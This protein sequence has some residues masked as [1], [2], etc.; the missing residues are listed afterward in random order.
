[1]IEQ[2]TYINNLGRFETFRGSPDTALRPFTLVYSENGCGKTTLCALLRSL[3]SGD[4]EPLHARKRVS[5]KNGPHAV[6][7]VEG[8]ERAFNG[9]AWNGAGPKVLVFDDHFTAANVC[10]GLEVGAGHRQKLHELVVGEDG[11]RLQRRVEE[12]TE[13]I[14]GHQA[15]LR[16][17]VREIPPHVLGDNSLDD[18]CALPE[19]EN[20]DAQLVEATKCASVLRNQ[21][22][23]GATPGFSPIALPTL[24]DED[25]AGVLGAVLPDLDAEALEAVSRHFEKLGEG[26][27]RWVSEGAKSSEAEECPFCGQATA[28]VDLV[29]HYRRYFSEAYT[30]H[31]KRIAQALGK[32]RET[33]GGDRLARFQRLLSQAR[34]LRMFWADYVEGLPPFAVDDDAVAEAWAGARDALLE[35]LEAKAQAPL[36]QLEFDELA[37]EKFTRYGGLAEPMLE[38]STALLDKNGDV[39]LAKEHATHGNLAAAE[40]Q[41]RHLEA[42]NRRHEPEVAKKC[43]AY[44]RAKVAKE[45]AETD[46]GS[47]RKALD[48]HRAKTFGKYQASINRF[49]VKFH[50]DFRLETLGPSDPRGIPTSTYAI[51]VNRGRVPLAS[52]KVEPSFGTALSAGD[53][54]T[55]ALA[56][57]FSMLSERGTLD[58][59][60]VVIDDPA[61]SLDDNRCFATVQ[62]IRKLVGRARQVVVLSHARPFLCQLWDKADKDETVALEIRDAGS[63]SSMLQA[64]DADAAAVTEYDRLYKTVA[65]YAESGQ[66]DSQQVATSLRMLLEGYCRVA[67]IEGFPARR[68]LGEFINI[69]R[70]A[71][72]NGAPLLTNERLEELN[73]LREYSNQFH[74]NTS[75]AWQANL[76]NVNERELKGYARRVLGFVRG[77]D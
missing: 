69:A 62:E 42:S 52:R 20:M 4:P 51:G 21:E 30:R 17:K 56:L 67:F 23:V 35:R 75:K 13:Q 6:V 53:R 61:S 1:M 14:S 38:L 57:F 65:E 2:F 19:V 33:F 39:A 22:K 37:Q 31:K 70:Q 25:V 63:E 72:A 32:V 12:L 66:G 29:L 77:G 45:Q 5:G 59:A 55:L 47:A 10:S 15:V 18:F 76:A 34:K 3:S 74:H 71:V 48:E 7:V 27:E 11:I 36:E 54:N 60:V 24:P 40:A 8:H 68:L 9:S 44:S 50:A 43:E 58:D 41:L 46:K 73:D 49:L 16:E 28:G 64:W 26:G